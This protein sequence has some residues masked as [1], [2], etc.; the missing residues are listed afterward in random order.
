N[1]F[2]PDQYHNMDNPMAHEQTFSEI[3]NTL[4]KAP[5]FIFVST[6]TCGTL[7]GL[8]DAIINQAAHTKIIAVDAEGS[9]IFGDEPNK[10]I[11][12]G[13]GASRRSKFLVSEQVED[14]VLISDKESV[15]GCYQ[16]LNTESILAGGSSG[17]VIKAIEKKLGSIAENSTVVAILAD[18]GERYLNTIYSEGWLKDNFNI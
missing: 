16:L 11:I 15:E 10:R 9:V 13:M 3:L 17:A 6:S 8:G 4:G 18:S 1:S 2:W 12:P 14:V 7:R 5:D